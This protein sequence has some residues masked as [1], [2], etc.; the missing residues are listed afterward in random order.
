MPD[1][2]TRPENRRAT[3]AS[4]PGWGPDAV[5]M[6]QRRRAEDRAAFVLPFLSATDRVLDVGC[7][8]GT[9]TAGLARAV[10]E[11][12][13]IGIDRVP[14]QIGLARSATADLP[15]AGFG[16]GSVDALP[17]ADAAVDAVFAHA[18]LEHLPAPI[19]ALREC[20]RV[21]RPGGIVA[22]SCS[23]WSRAHLEP[24]DADVRDA[25]AGHHL[26]RRRAGGDPF[27]GTSLPAWVADAGF[28][29]L[30]VRC[31]DRVDLA[32]DALARY[33]GA[34]LDVALTAA[35]GLANDRPVLRRAADAA[36]RW[37]GRR[38]SATQCW[39]EVTARR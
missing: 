16:V 13:A 11:G 31:V 10:P 35:D 33:V 5:A 37:A 22:L 3:D 32:Y 15:T 26:L 24:F 19:E 17:V 28:T 38:G 8:P 34:R 9:M 6:L 25:M 20:R 2:A 14:S 4:A 27:A 7:G 23:D 21:L 1:G 29:D 18:L 39:V 36:G 12:R 30:A